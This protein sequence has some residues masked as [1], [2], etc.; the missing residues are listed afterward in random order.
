[1]KFDG[2]EAEMEARTGTSILKETIKKNKRKTK[3]MEKQ[4]RM[5]DSYILSKSTEETT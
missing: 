3:R 2:R 1:V 5:G 4:T